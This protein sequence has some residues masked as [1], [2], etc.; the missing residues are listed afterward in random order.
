[1]K[2]K[3]YIIC[4]YAKANWGKTK[5]LLVV[6]DLLTK[7]NCEIIKKEETKE[8]DKW[9]HFKF[10]NGKEVVISTLGDP[11]SEQLR[12]L[13]EAAKTRAEVI[14]TAS[15]ARGVARHNVENIADKHGYSIIKF[16]NFHFED[17]VEDLLITKIRKKEA[18]KIVEE[19]S[20]L[21]NS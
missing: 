16:A 14:V 18:E 3:K 12:W 8:G 5:T 10:K 17:Y 13:K 2:E 9:Y 20:I 15:R 19:I 11:D 21:L 7:S 6:I 4:N 1:M